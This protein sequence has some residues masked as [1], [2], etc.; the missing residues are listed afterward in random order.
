MSRPI[1]M[2]A[3]SVGWAD[4]VVEAA[5]VGDHL[6]Q[7][8][9]VSGD[10]SPEPFDLDRAVAAPI[11]PTTE[12]APVSDRL[13][14]LATR[15]PV[16]SPR[17]APVSCATSGSI[18]SRTTI[19]TASRSRSHCPSPPIAFAT[20]S[21]VVIIRS[22]AVVVLL[23]KQCSRRCDRLRPIGWSGLLM[24]AARTSASFPGPLVGLREI[25]AANPRTAWG[26]LHQ[27]WC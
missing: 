2:W 16:R 5:E 13:P 21:P 9:A 25:R 7:L 4:L 26:H 24:D 11:T 23:L 12:P 20:T 19:P 17:P 27:R 15:P 8:H 3:T 1:G 10:F 22:S 6:L 18:N 14:Y